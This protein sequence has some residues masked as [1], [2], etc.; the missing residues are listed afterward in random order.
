MQSRLDMVLASVRQRSRLGEKRG[1][2][3]ATPRKPPGENHSEVYSVSERK[4]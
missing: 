2:E 3:Q 4:P 1:R